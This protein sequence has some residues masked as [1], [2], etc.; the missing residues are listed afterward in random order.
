M[1]FNFVTPAIVIII[2]M[3]AEL[4]KLFVLKTNKQRSWLPFWCSISGIVIS[5]IIYFV[6]PQGTN[7]ANVVEAFASGALSGFA[8]TG[9]NQ[10]Y[11]QFSRYSG[12]YYHDPGN[13]TCSGGSKCIN[14]GSNNADSEENIT[15]GNESEPQD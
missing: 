12:G 8:A 7:A 15:Y 5:L 14:C 10:L 11:K 9:C 4:L 13:T 3:V 1:D 2:Y 6:Y